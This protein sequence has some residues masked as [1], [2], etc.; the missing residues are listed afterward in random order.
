MNVSVQAP[1]APIFCP[2]CNGENPA[3]RLEIIGVM[4]R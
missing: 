4:T 1:P 3:V 2:V